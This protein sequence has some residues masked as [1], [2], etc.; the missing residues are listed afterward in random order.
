M[1][2]GN[3]FSSRQAA[4]LNTLA[5]CRSANPCSYVIVGPRGL[6]EAGEYV[7]DADVPAE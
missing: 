5:L 3:R 1:S 6:D 7:S 4:K 2:D